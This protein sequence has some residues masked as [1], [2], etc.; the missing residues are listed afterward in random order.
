MGMRTED[1]VTK[2][3]AI[4]AAAIATVLTSPAWGTESRNEPTPTPGA[5]AQ[6]ATPKKDDGSQRK[7]YVEQAKDGRGAGTDW[8]GRKDGKEDKSEGKLERH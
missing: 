1:N 2:S 8:S 3:N 6:T 7:Q 5:Q 4:F